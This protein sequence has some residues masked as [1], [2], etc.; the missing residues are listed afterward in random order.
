MATADIALLVL[1]IALLSTTSVGAA[2]FSV[3]RKSNK[4][5]AEAALAEEAL[6]QERLRTQILEE[7]LKNE[8]LKDLDPR[9]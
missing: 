2:I 6:K 4:E 7:Q 3:F 5:K 8:I 9:H 1:V